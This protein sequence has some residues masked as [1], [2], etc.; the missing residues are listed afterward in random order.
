[1]ITLVNKL[2]RTYSFLQ[3]SSV[4]NEYDKVDLKNLCSDAFLKAP[5]NQ[6]KLTSSL[7]LISDCLFRHFRKPVI[8]L[9]DEYDVPL[10]KAASREYHKDIVDLISAFLGVLK[11]TPQ[12]TNEE[13]ASIA[14]VVMTGC[15]KVAKNSIFTGVNNVV[16]NTV[17]NTQS[18]FTSIIGFN[19]D[20]TEKLL[21]DYN[22]ADYKDMVR[23]NYDGYRFDDAEM[24]CPWDVI[25][26]VANNYKHKLN[27]QEYKIKPDNYWINT[28]FSEIL[29]DYVGYLSSSVTQRL[30]DLVDRKTIEVCIN[31]L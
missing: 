17:L 16:V 3:T 28:S 27:H 12:N 30:Q 10:A 20:E 8:L 4:L 1:M 31:V 18:Q 19:K 15:L 7:N 9:I 5:I 23:E 11:R 13:T 26:F 21:E 2:A 25:N 22:L 24:F 29:K 14:K 6:N